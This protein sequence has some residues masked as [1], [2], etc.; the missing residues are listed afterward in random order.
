VTTSV[1]RRTGWVIH[2]IAD[3]DSGRSIDGI[4]Q[5]ARVTT[6]CLSHCGID[7]RED[8]NN[9]AAVTKFG[10]TWH[11]S[12]LDVLEEDRRAAEHA[13]RTV[14]AETLGMPSDWLLCDEDVR[15]EDRAD[16]SDATPDWTADDVE[17]DDVAAT[18]DGSSSSSSTDPDPGTVELTVCDGTLE[19]IQ[20]AGD[21]LEDPEWLRQAQHAADLRAEWRRWSH[22]TG[23][24]G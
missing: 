12:D 15:I 17:L 2:R 13:V 3:E 6:Y 21:Y 24:P 11:R 7:V 19:D 1:E 22:D 4:E 10:S 8:A 5:A 14:A 18:A 23:P 9:R 20:H 16:R